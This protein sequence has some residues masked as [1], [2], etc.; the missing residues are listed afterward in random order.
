MAPSKGSSKRKEPPASGDEGDAKRKKYFYQ[1]KF[2]GC[3]N[4]RQKGGVCQRHGAKQ[5][6]YRRKCSA[7]GCPNQATKGGVC[8]RH[9]ADAKK[10]SVEDC[11]NEARKDGV[12][13]Q[14]GAERKKCSA[15]GCDN[16]AVKGGVCRRHGA[17]RECSVEGC[18]NIAV[19]G[20]VCIRH[21]ATQKTCKKKDCSSLAQGGHKGYCRRHS[22][23]RCSREGC[24]LKMESAGLCS[25]HY[26]ARK[27]V[28]SDDS[29]N[30]DGRATKRSRKEVVSGKQP[31]PTGFNAMPVALGSHDDVSNEGTVDE[32]SPM[33]PGIPPPV[34]EQPGLDEAAEFAQRRAAE[35]DD[36]R[37]QNDGEFGGTDNNIFNGDD[38]NVGIGPMQIAVDTSSVT[39]SP[40]GTDAVEEEVGALLANSG[41][42]S[43]E[44]SRSGGGDETAAPSA[45]DPPTIEEAAP[46]PDAE[47]PVAADPTEEYPAEPAIE[48]ATPAVASSVGIQSSHSNESHDSVEAS[49]EEAMPEEAAEEAAAEETPVDTCAQK[50][51]LF[52]GHVSF[53]IFSACVVVFLAYT[54]ASVGRIGREVMLPSL[55][56]SGEKALNNKKNVEDQLRSLQDEHDKAT[57][58]LKAL[59]TEISVSTFE[60]ECRIENLEKDLSNITEE[61]DRQ[62]QAL[63]AEL[64][65]AHNTADGLW[66]ERLMLTAQVQNLEIER[67]DAKDTVQKMWEQHEAKMDEMLA[68]RKDLL[69]TLDQTASN[70][71]NREERIDR[72]GRDSE[73][74]HKNWEAK[75]IRLN[76]ENEMLKDAA[77]EAMDKIRGLEE[78]EGADDAKTS[79]S[80]V[81]GEFASS[82]EE[83]K[84]I[85]AG[86]ATYHQFFG[87][88][89][90]MDPLTSFAIVIAMVFVCWMNRIRDYKSSD[91]RGGNRRLAGTQLNPNE[92]ESA[93]EEESAGVK[94]RE[95]VE[96]SESQRMRRERAEELERRRATSAQIANEAMMRAQEMQQR[97]REGGSRRT[98]GVR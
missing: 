13:Q 24:S 88:E 70:L 87:T 75:I 85:P 64:N 19:K 55:R 45:E 92:T 60:Y 5:K 97:R 2:S 17:K 65:E 44:P 96:E 12:C 33:A 49:I 27:Q 94:A 48:E 9:G 59:E 16:Q 62:I 18:P 61:M 37:D 29:D 7:E 93:D 77:M 1:C 42:L 79:E 90:R 56:T 21:G 47:L 38:E 15:E 82:D 52:R 51:C 30:E 46:A 3:T 80:S 72:L 74:Q 83:Q 32:S 23:V 50:R 11:N 20:G 81:V 91:A 78:A 69:D 84:E 35:L 41:S 73:M 31:S 8:R 40:G 66:K 68:E 26:K 43:F 67:D 98:D 10:C 39:G 89:L 14:H 36:V 57:S 71:A 25:K 86:P 34:I 53:V 28:V 6:Q 22:D 95:E 76:E 58:N 63:D 54:I 4:R